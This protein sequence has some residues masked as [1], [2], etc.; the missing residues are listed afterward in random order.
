VLNFI[1]ALD[2]YEY[3]DLQTDRSMNHSL[4]KLH[5]KSTTKRER[6]LGVLYGT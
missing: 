2:G 3:Y 1:K 6:S 5:T 4:P